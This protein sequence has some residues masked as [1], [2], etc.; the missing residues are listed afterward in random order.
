MK[1]LDEQDMELVFVASHR[2]FASADAF[3]SKVGNVE[4]VNSSSREVTP[5]AGEISTDPRRVS[6]P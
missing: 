2:L 5:F 4:T 6:W 1:L 3:E